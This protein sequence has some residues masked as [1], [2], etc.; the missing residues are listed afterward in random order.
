[1]WWNGWELIFSCF[2]CKHLFSDP[3]T[4]K[5]HCG[6]GAVILLYED[7]TFRVNVKSVFRCEI[8]L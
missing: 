8:I 6:G 3:G 5:P 2:Y 1:M 7:K 4:R